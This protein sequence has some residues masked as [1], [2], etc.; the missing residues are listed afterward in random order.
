M[1]NLI[2]FSITLWTRYYYPHFTDER[3]ET[4]SYQQALLRVYYV[5]GRMWRQV[6]PLKELNYL[7][8][9]NNSQEGAKK[10][11]EGNGSTQ[12]RIIVEEV[13]ESAQCN[14]ERAVLGLLLIGSWVSQSE[15]RGQRWKGNASVWGPKVGGI[16]QGEEDTWESQEGSL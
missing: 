6:P 7:M 3:T 15:G 2:R 9:R 13:Q 10:G 14:L 16:F 11:L 1:L 5:L 8:G 12:R 4:E